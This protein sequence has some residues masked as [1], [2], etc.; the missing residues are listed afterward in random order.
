MYILIIYLGKNN[1]KDKG[2]KSILENLEKNT[3]LNE[4]NIGKAKIILG[5]NGIT[6]EMKDPILNLIKVNKALK[7]LKL[8]KLILNN[9]DNV[10]IYYTIMGEIKAA[11]DKVGISIQT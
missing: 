4:L 6:D 1:I 7:T 9:V 2:I 3:M 10:N 5:N 8:C 11:G